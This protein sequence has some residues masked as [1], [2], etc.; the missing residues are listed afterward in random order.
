MKAPVNGGYLHAAIYFTHLTNCGQDLILH[1][2]FT[3]GRLMYSLNFE[4]I[5]RGY[6]KNIKHIFSL[7]YIIL[8]VG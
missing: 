5:E 4:N 6:E 1:L 2:G 3:L 7:D 8:L